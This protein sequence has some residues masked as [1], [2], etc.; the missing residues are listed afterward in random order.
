[1]A[2]FPRGGMDYPVEGEFIPKEDLELTPE[3]LANLKSCRWRMNNLYMVKD[4]NG[5]AVQ[6]RMNEA[7]E[8]LFNGMHTRN[9][10]LKARQLGFTTFVLMLMLDQCLWLKDMNCGVVANGKDKVEELFRNKI[11]WTYN[12]L[13]AVIR[14]LHP[15]KKLT[16]SQIVFNNDSSIICAVSLRSGTYQILLISEYGKICKEFPKRALEI[17]TGTLETVHKENLVFIES[18]AEGQS[19]KFYD[20]SKAAQ[21][22]AQSAVKLTKLHYKFFF[23]AWWQN[24]INTLD[25]DEAATVVIP[26]RLEEYFYQLEEEYGFEFTQGQRAWYALKEGGEDGDGLGDLMKQEHPSHPDEAFEKIVEGAY[27]EKQFRAIRR[28]GRITRVPH[29]PLIPVN[30]CWDIGVGDATAIWCYQNVGREIHWIHFYENSGEAVGFYWDYLKELGYQRWG[31]HWAPH[32]IKVRQFGVR[33]PKTG[34]PM[35]RLESAA[36]EGLKFEICPDI[37]VDDGI[38]LVRRALGISWFDE[39]GCAKGITHL[40]EYRKQWDTTHG[41]WRDIP[42]HDEHSDG[43]DSMRYGAVS[44]PFFRVARSQS[45]SKDTNKSARNQ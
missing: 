44:H 23:Y 45:K 8:A 5:D 15:A 13:P 42:L 25:E 10:I 6:F 7:Q 36:Q 21:R 33:N 26:A 29:D 39:V 27:Y 32:D 20:R 28:E 9:L 3:L 11:L 4:E 30:T 38:A 37:P 1:M 12:H 31:T 40:Q 43:A 22:R 16:S 34:K 2:N 14:D 41:V 18:T 19:G 24:P 17:E 35:T